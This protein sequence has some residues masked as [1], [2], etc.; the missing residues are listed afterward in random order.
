MRTGYVFLLSLGLVLG[1]SGCGKGVDAKL[2]TENEQAY[3]PSLNKAWQ[4]MSPEQQQAY[5]WAV[6]NFSLEQLVAKYPSMTP[7]TVINKEADEYIKLKT[8]EVAS[9]TAELT[10]NAERL[11]QEE[12]SVRGVTAELAKITA[13][14]IGISNKSF[15][16]AK[17][18]VFVTQNDSQF[19]V[20]SAQ[21][22]AWLF[23]DDEQKSDRHCS[24]RAYY[25]VYG[26]LPHGKSLKY[27]FDVG[28]MDCTNWDTLEVKNAK[29]KRFKLE[30]DNASVE[31]FG[32][33]KILPHYST[34][35]A[36]YEN[37][38]KKAKDEIEVA[39]KAKATL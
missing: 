3:R 21:W 33:K 7:R 5:N 37:A 1:L 12:K 2:A 30:L 18:F 19:D 16:I 29:T 20:S 32:E 4:D 14:G 31:N 13:T 39:M 8:Q 17:E 38:I 25:K 10:K 28:F 9:I 11:A 22:D 24:V 6:S 34:T 23:I 35:R 27:S 26:G 15:G 36:D